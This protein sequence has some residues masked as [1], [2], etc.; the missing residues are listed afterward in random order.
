MT[1]RLRN[2]ELQENSDSESD[3][4][5][6]YQQEE[7]RDESGSQTPSPGLSPTPSSIPSPSPASS[8]SSPPLE[9]FFPKRVTRSF[10]PK[11][12]KAVATP[13]V[14]KTPK[15]PKNPKILEAPSAPRTIVTRA[16]VNKKQV[17]A[18]GDQAEVDIESVGD[19]NPNLLKTPTAKKPRLR[20]KRGAGGK[21]P[22]DEEVESKGN[23]KPVTTPAPKKSGAKAKGHGSGGHPEEDVE[24]EEDIKP[25]KA[26]THKR[27]RTKSHG[28]G[29]ARG[30]A[31]KTRGLRP[32]KSSKKYVSNATAPSIAS[33][34]GSDIGGD[35][36]PTG[37]SAKVWSPLDSSMDGIKSAAMSLNPNRDC[38]MIST[39]IPQQERNCTGVYDVL[40]RSPTVLLEAPI[41]DKTGEDTARATDMRS[42]F[43]IIKE[44]RR[45]P[46]LFAPGVLVGR[47]QIGSSAPEDKHMF[48]LPVKAES[49]VL[50]PLGSG[51][52]YPTDPTQLIS[53][54]TPS[55]S[56][57]TPPR[58]A[59]PKLDL[60]TVQPWKWATVPT[61]MSSMPNF[62]ARINN[63]SANT[64]P[65]T[66][67]LDPP[68]AIDNVTKIVDKTYDEASQYLL[69]AMKLTKRAIADQAH[70]I[71]FHT[72][73]FE[74]F[75]QGLAMTEYQCQILCPQ[76]H[77]AFLVASAL[78]ASPPLQVPSAAVATSLS[79][80]L[81]PQAQT[82]TSTR[83]ESLLINMIKNMKR[84]LEAAIVIVLVVS[85]IIKTALSNIPL[86]SIDTFQKSD[87]G[88]D[89]ATATSWR[90]GNYCT[91][92]V[93]LGLCERFTRR[94][95]LYEHFQRR[96]DEKAIQN[97]A[98]EQQR[99][100]IPSLQQERP[101]AMSTF[102]T[103]RVQQEDYHDKQSNQ[104]VDMGHSKATTE[105]MDE[106]RT[107][108][109]EEVVVVDETGPM[110]IQLTLSQW[111][112]IKELSTGLF[113]K[114]VKSYE[115]SRDADRV[116][117]DSH[118][119]FMDASKRWYAVAGHHL[120][121][122]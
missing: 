110:R 92:A 61:P 115:D 106:S 41:L 87:D 75:R 79:A 32:K 45:S 17:A 85:I 65:Y 76:E 120:L 96:R 40:L 112:R 13:K 57:M 54:Q 80:T 105:M 99:D 119:R 15:T 18:R 21:A 4:D 113:L 78:L 20:T 64:T 82:L 89:P 95:V 25:V 35:G 72:V 81:T 66:A 8:T 6:V 71:R 30:L 3:D 22:S 88:P 10:T 31:K 107:K 90:V 48:A 46:T 34:Q 37:L 116:A 109:E 103:P 16:R 97:S 84:E 100:S 122:R 38:E 62:L 19:P 42:V 60:R 104:E 77:F 5:D 114:A 29:A 121:P 36:S 69:G 70:A 94:K 58:S 83:D 108:E 28:P 50:E 117:S 24:S 91:L 2:R 23:V 74:V 51:P 26:L 39:A 52:I 86:P 12:N 53:T 102:A 59:V 101:P 111:S 7:D 63:T 73:A 44:E 9:T 1:R 56:L 43:S 118:D 49:H 11:V 67:A 33:I 47:R 27:P 68:E 55:S 93:K 98:Q 14:L